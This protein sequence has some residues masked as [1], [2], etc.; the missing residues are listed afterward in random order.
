MY[1]PLNLFESHLNL[2]LSEE[3]DTGKSVYTGIEEYDH[4]LAKTEEMRV[5]IQDMLAQIIHS[6]EEKSR[7]QLEKLRYQINPHFL[8]NTLNTV[9]WM[10]VLN[11]QQEID[12]IVQALNRLLFYNL[13]KDGVNTN[14]ERE[15]SAI[16]EYVLLQKVRYDFDFRVVRQPQDMVFE[17]PSPKFMLQPIIENSLNHGYRDNMEIEITVAGEGERIKICV[18]DN[19]LGISAEKVKALK[20]KI[21]RIRSDME[22]PEKTVM[23]IGLEYVTVMLDSFYRR[24]NEKAFFD[25]ESEEKGGTYVWLDLPKIVGNPTDNG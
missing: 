3:S 4:L 22:C 1:R 10:A 25:I 9:H 11:S 12:S 6:Q 14:L 19:G 13:D 21:S 5:R 2:L 20:E 18:K 15:L 8:M 16:N 23:G 17:Y 7:L 24:W